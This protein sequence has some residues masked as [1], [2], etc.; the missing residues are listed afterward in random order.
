MKN[1]L[2]DYVNKETSYAFKYKEKCAG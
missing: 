2:K 1:R